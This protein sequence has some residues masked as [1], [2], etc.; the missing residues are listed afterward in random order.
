MNSCVVA[1]HIGILKTG[2]ESLGELLPLRP[3]DAA[4]CGQCE[5]S[6]RML[7]PFVNDSTG[8]FTCTDCG[9]LGW[10]AASFPLDEMV[11]D[12]VEAA[13]C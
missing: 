7:I 6:G 8:E 11:V 12:R 13:P 10:K 1:V 9:G 5:G 2:I 4:A 3:D